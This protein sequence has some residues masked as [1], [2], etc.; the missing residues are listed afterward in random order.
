MEG[1]PAGEPEQSPALVVQLSDLHL[2]TGE[3]E[4]QRAARLASA[5]SRVA[6]L[7]PTPGAVL[8]SGD[9]AD[10]PS[11]TAYEQVHAL[12]ARL[13]VP[14]HAIPG[15]HDDRAMLRERFGPD[16]PAGEQVR[17]AVRCGPLRLLGCD[18][19]VPGREGGALGADQLHW[20]ARTLAEEPH[21]PT[22]LAL[23]H[24]PLATGVRSMD[25]IALD[26]EDSAALEEL[27]ED[28]P[29]VQ[30]IACGHVH[31]AMAST[32]AGRCLLVCPST[33]STLRLDL[34]DRA[35]LEF[36]TARLPL[37]FAVHALVDGRIVS[38]VQA[39]SASG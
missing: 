32:F 8:L 19:T 31:T 17:F 34:R 6:E 12:V 13:D 36:S 5:V 33:N 30:T 38:H 4:A 23:H 20:L 14:V 11:P 7:R 2:R 24:P 39:L 16:G 21:T 1:G 25:A 26:G 10:E 27:L 9:L 28:H 18:S 29:Q 15:N 37:G 3:D 35:D 22:L